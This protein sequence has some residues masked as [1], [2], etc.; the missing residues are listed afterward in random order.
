M[1]GM[2]KSREK[3]QAMRT[4]IQQKA[5]MT[6]EEL[7]G[8]L[9][10]GIRAEQLD[11]VPEDALTAKNR[12]SRL[13]TLGAQKRAMESGL[14]KESDVVGQRPPRWENLLSADFTVEQWKNV[15]VEVED[16]VPDQI[17][18][19]GALLSIR[20]KAVEL[21]FWKRTYEDEDMMKLIFEAYKMG[22]AD[23]KK[24]IAECNHGSFMEKVKEIIDTQ[25]KIID[26]LITDNEEKVNPV[27]SLTPR[28]LVERITLYFI[29]CDLVKKFYTVPGLAFYIGFSSREDFMD[30]INDNPDSIHLHIITRAMTYIEAERVADMLYGGGLMAGHK[31]DLATN[32]NYND[33]GK[34]SEGQ[35]PQTNITVN[36]N[37]LSMETAAPKA[38][39][40]EEW[41]AWYKKEQAKKRDVEHLG[42]VVDVK[43]VS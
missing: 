43:P 19:P 2:R 7:G 14:V 40:I 25:R 27:L 36:N 23:A 28:E 38:Q 31:L 24:N 3:A 21:E 30:Y 22:A 4:E 42:T 17:C 34:K 9:L 16:L 26:F 33:A 6:R 13:S 41:Q 10:K 20:K 1:A 8:Q 12:I 32:F 39:S 18:E 35:A 15:Q 5:K 29:E 11:T 37:T